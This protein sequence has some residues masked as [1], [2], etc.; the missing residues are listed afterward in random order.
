VF[1][2]KDTSIFAE[3]DSKGSVYKVPIN[4]PNEVVKWRFGKGDDYEDIV[5]L[6]STFYIML[7]TGR[8]TAARFTGDD[9]VLVDTY[10]FP[11]GEK[12]EFEGMYYEPGTRKMVLVCKDCKVD[13]D[14]DE[15]LHTYTFD[16]AT[17]SFS[18]QSYVVNV[19]E[20]DQFIGEPTG[21]F[22]PSAAAIHPITGDLYFL[23][24]VNKLLVKSDR[25]GK[26]KG[27]WKLRPATFKQPEGIAFT[28]AGSLIISNESADIGP[29]N[30]LIFPWNKTTTKAPKP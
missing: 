3:S 6:D 20:I 1:Y 29:S 21:R 27:A 12:N 17:G 22:K 10:D 2:P 11:Y 4:R 25:Q 30:V 24:S 7:S 26:V 23:S 14:H 18:D 19:R 13:D 5:L 8:I 15:S 9:S 28:P 16:P